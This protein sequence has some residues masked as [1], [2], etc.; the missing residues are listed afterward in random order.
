MKGPLA[1]WPVRTDDAFLIAMISSVPWLPAEWECNIPMVCA[2]D[3]AAWQAMALLRESVEWAKRRRCA[4]WRV[5]SETDFDLGPMAVRL[6][7]TEISPRYV[8]RL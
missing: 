7:A 2:D 1:F 8:L 3:G 4:T 6:G 5:V